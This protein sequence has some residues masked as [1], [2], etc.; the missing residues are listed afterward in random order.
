MVRGNDGT[1]KVDCV[2]NYYVASL[3]ELVSFDSMKQCVTDINACYGYGS[4]M[5]GQIA[6]DLRWAVKGKW[7]DKKTWAPIGPGSKR[8]MN[9]FRKRSLKYNLKQ[10]QFLGEMNECS[11]LLRIT[12]P[13]IYERLEAI[14]IQNTLCEFD[15]Y[16]RA[17]AEAGRPKQ[18]YEGL[19]N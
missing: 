2:I 13:N 7:K 3:P 6:A 16:E 15:K 12:Y 1:D 11:K 14:D 8:G 4:F 17:L 5:A 19:K 10:Q 18:K 9:R